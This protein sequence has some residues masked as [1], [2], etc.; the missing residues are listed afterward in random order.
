MT[1]VR[2]PRLTKQNLGFLAS[3][4]KWMLRDVEGTQAGRR[5]KTILDW[6]LD[7]IEDAPEEEGQLTNG[8]EAKP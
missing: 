5:W 7:Q 3:Q 6:A 8:K 4:A 2:R 1:K